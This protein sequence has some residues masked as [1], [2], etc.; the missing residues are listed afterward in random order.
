MESNW[1]KHIWAPKQFKTQKNDL[2]GALKS[3]RPEKTKQGRY[4]HQINQKSSLVDLEW[5]LTGLNTS[6]RQN[7]S[8]HKKSTWQRLQSQSNLV[9]VKKG[10]ISTKFI[11]KL[12]YEDLE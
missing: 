6:E 10:V 11:K 4:Q 1:L 2:A 8:K 12:I 7:N 3:T 9:N 5:S